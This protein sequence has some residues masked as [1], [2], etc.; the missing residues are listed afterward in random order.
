MCR[1]K[2]QRVAAEMRQLVRGFCLAAALLAL[3]S[4]P[5]AAERPKRDAK[6]ARP[7]TP[8]PAVVPFDPTF[9]EHF[10]GPSDAEDQAALAAV[11]I[12]PQEERRLGN[13]AADAYMHELRSRGVRVTTRGAVVQYLRKLVETLQPRLQ[14]HDRYRTVK[15]YLADSPQVDAR[16]FPGGTIVVFRGLLDFADS[17]AALVGVL[18]HELSHFDRGHQL[19]PLKRI[20]L[21]RQ[22][23]DGAAT[24][25]LKHMLAAGGQMARLFGRPFR[26]EDEAQADEDGATWAYQSGYD[27]REMARL[28]LRMHEREQAK[29]QPNFM[30][31]FL[32]THPFSIDRYRAIMTHYENLAREQPSETLHVGRKNLA[33]R[34]PCSEQALDP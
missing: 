12:E 8:P 4:T 33:R 14:N 18:G 15:V 7:E 5:G 6:R 31:A 25:D 24:A 9:F 27:P 1:L 11:K 2:R 29:N 32:R 13:A 28:F 17:E 10:F 26:P 19:L 16:S 34:I 30:P 22:A 3:A 21:A 20:K 23:V